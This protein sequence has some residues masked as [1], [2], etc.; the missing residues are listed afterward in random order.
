MDNESVI[1]MTEYYSATQRKDDNTDGLQGH[2]AKR[3]RSERERQMLYYLP[4][5]W[6]WSLFFK[7]KDS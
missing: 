6:M 7:K 4:F 5:M 1:D 2:Y 3:N